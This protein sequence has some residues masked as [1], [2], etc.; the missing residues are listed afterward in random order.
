M[1]DRSPQEQR[2]PAVLQWAVSQLSEPGQLLS[3]LPL[4]GAGPP[5]LPFL[6]SLW[7]WDL[8]CWSIFP[9]S[10]VLASG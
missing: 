1:R 5:C 2:G 6:L 9:C 7:A 3:L 4:K 8:V 10:S